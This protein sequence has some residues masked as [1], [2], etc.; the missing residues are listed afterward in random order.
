LAGAGVLPDDVKNQFLAG[1]VEASISQGCLQYIGSSPQAKEMAKIVDATSRMVPQCQWDAIISN[2][3]PQTFQQRAE[4]SFKG[5]WA[6][7]HLPP[8]NTPI[9]LKNDPSVSPSGH[10]V[11]RP[12]GMP[13]DC[14]PSP[15]HKKLLVIQV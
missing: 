11:I 9:S 1:A 2:V 6:K 10:Q 13:S 15:P 5:N 12:P 7:S 8:Q 3:G 14:K 4:S